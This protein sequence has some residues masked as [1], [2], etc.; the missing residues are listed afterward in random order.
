MIKFISNEIS[1]KN[2]DFSIFI[3]KQ[4][5]VSDAVEPAQFKYFINNTDNT[6]LPDKTILKI[7]FKELII[8]KITYK[9]KSSSTG[10]LF[11]LSEEEIAS[12]TEHITL[13]FNKQTCLSIF[14][15]T[16][17]IPIYFLEDTHFT[18][19]VTNFL[20]TVIF[21]PH[22]LTNDKI[23][24]KLDTEHDTNAIY[25]K[26]FKLTK[27]SKTLQ[28]NINITTSEL[29][30]ITEIYGITYTKDTQQQI[31][32]F[33]PQILKFAP[34]TLTKLKEL[35][36]LLPLH[37][38]DTTEKAE[39]MYKFDNITKEKNTDVMILLFIYLLGHALSN[40]QSSNI[41][42]LNR[43]LTLYVYKYVKF[44]IDQGSAIVTT[45]EHLKYFF[46]SNINKI[47]E[48]NSNETAKA[49][50][51]TDGNTNNKAMTLYHNDAKIVDTNMLD[52]PRI[53]TKST[54][55]IINDKSTISLEE[56]VNFG[57]MSKY[58]LLSILQKLKNGDTNLKSY[59]DK[60]KEPHILNLQKNTTQSNTL[61]IMLAHIK[62]YSGDVKQLNDLD[63]KDHELNPDLANTLNKICTAEFDT[64]EFAQSI[65]ST[66]QGIPIPMKAAGATKGGSMFTK[67]KLNKLNKLNNSK[68]TK[69][70]QHKFDFS[71]LYKKKH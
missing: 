65:S 47:D 51:K 20:T 33:E 48:Y 9:N 25:F 66:T 56:R 18:D 43:I 53:Y 19:I 23:K 15:V 41:N 11:H 30:K 49:K 64:L 29:D 22:P 42:N 4:R 12:C 62:C 71:S 35:L 36:P 24:E 55:L 1:K 60:T 10:D 45:L 46:L 21:Q 7:M 63:I 32:K 8:T 61:F 50:A 28:E 6:K 37:L 31:P 3:L 13:F 44:I 5:S 52:K 67:N 58:R 34:F 57:E 69:E 26:Y 54:K 39:T 17:K 38:L 14:D 2:K 68:F 27:Q 16:P 59:V 70:S 40:K